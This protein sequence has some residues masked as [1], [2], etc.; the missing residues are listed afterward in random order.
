MLCNNSWEEIAVA[1][2]RAHSPFRFCYACLYA[3]KTIS[4]S[5]GCADARICVNRIVVWFT[6]NCFA[7]N[8]TKKENCTVY[9]INKRLCVIF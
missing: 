7:F 8:H 4:F 9:Q 6:G 1:F 2:N 5:S 3:C